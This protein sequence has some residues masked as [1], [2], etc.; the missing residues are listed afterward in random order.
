MKLPAFGLFAVMFSA[1]MLVAAP[2]ATRPAPPGS[3]DELVDRYLTAV[4]AGDAAAITP[5]LAADSVVNQPGKIAPGA[6][7]VRGL[8]RA[9]GNGIVEFP[10]TLQGSSIPTKDHTIHGVTRV[11]RDGGQ[12]KVVADTLLSR[13]GES[14]I[15]TVVPKASPK[16]AV[17]RAGDALSAEKTARAI[18]DAFKRGDDAAV[19]AQLTQKAR[20]TIAQPPK[21]GPDGPTHELKFK[22]AGP[23]ATYE[24]LDV[25]AETGGS[26]LVGVRLTDP[27]D[28]M[29]SKGGVVRLRLK[30]DGA[31]WRVYKFI[32]FID[33]AAMQ[34]WDAEDPSRDAG[35][36]ELM[37]GKLAAGMEQLPKAIGESLNGPAAPTKHEPLKPAPGA[38]TPS[39][40]ER[41][42]KTE[43]PINNAPADASI[44]SLCDAAHLKLLIDPDA[45]PALKKSVTLKA[46]SFTRAEAIESIC[47]QLGVHAV[48]P[49]QQVEWPAK[50]DSDVVHIL[51]GPRKDRI[52]FAGPFIVSL[53]SL[54]QFPPYATGRVKVSV[55]SVGFP[56]GSSAEN[57]SRYMTKPAQV[58]TATSAAGEDLLDPEP[59]PFAPAR[60]RN[61]L[62]RVD[63]VDLTVKLIATLPTKVIQLRIDKLEA[64]AVAVDAG[65]SV[66][67]QQ[68][69]SQEVPPM[70]GA[71]NAPAR[72]FH[73]TFNID[74]VAYRNLSMQFLDDKG[75]VIPSRL[76]SGMGSDSNGVV[77]FAM[78]DQPVKVIV[79]GVTETQDVP[80]TARFA[81]V[82]LP[83]AARMPEALTSLDLRGHPIPVTI[84]SPTLTKKN[85]VVPELQA[86]VTNHTN[87]P[88]RRIAVEAETRDA[89]APSRA[90]RVHGSF[91]EGSMSP[92]VGAGDAADLTTDSWGGP[93][94]PGPNTISV[95]RVEFADGTIWVA[96]AVAKPN[97]PVVG[98]AAPK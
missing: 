39:E 2:P 40:F 28:P 4:T 18:M 6:S 66:K 61:L 81:G 13:G 68:I 30:R 74:G 67:L 25:S 80:Y 17:P 82:P 7:I 78:S 42:W 46:G 85:G 62:R 33:G 63:K 93:S 1:A 87:K 3:P 12:W 26:R 77:T 41:S 35:I 83:L 94:G 43:S 36:M 32:Y 69:Q 97:V 22:A 98:G 84:E 31:E 11:R 29:F 14:L 52:A 95:T 8:S 23:D 71:G 73:A 75:L 9:A 38:V 57:A 21:A 91:G 37:L 88:I 20:Q 90:H 89:F 48:F 86:K 49:G 44:R 96:Q 15:E 72:E 58:V 55:T 16:S 60:L 76:E 27:A 34:I 64:G 53:D 45:T 5:I 59:N 56:D 24:I 92:I 54:E 70:F 47:T 50:L 19:K 65:V 51:P 79:T 10:Y